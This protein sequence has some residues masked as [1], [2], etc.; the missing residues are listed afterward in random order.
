VLSAEDPTPPTVMGH[1]SG[2]PSIEQLSGV[3]AHGRTHASGCKHWHDSAVGKGIVLRAKISDRS[4][5][6]KW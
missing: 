5:S 2:P 4:L 6:D 3:L 1:T